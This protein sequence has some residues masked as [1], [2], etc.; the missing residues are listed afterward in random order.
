MLGVLLEGEIGNVRVGQNVD[1]GNLR[2]QL[3]QQLQPLGGQLG[4]IVADAGEV[5]ARLA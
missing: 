4:G 3:L 1:S 2:V 5:A